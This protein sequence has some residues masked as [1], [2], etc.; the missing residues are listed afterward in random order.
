MKKSLAV[1]AR[2]TALTAVAVAAG[3]GE[4][5]RAPTSDPI[6]GVLQALVDEPNPPAIDVFE[7][8][9]C[10]VP[11]GVTDPLYADDAERVSLTA[12]G[13]IT[14]VAS[15]VADYFTTVSHGAYTPRFRAGGTV[16]IDRDDTS[17]TCIERAL[18][19]SSDEA[20]AVLVVATAQHVADQP[21]GRATPGDRTDAPAGL[22]GRMVYVGANDF[23]R[24]ALQPI[25]L[26][27]L[28]HE[29]GHSLGLAHSGDAV[30][31][32]GNR[33]VGPYDLMADPAS[34]RLVHPARRDGPDL[35]LAGRIALGWVPL[36]DVEVF[37]VD[38]LAGEGQAVS[39]SPSTGTTGTR[40]AIVVVDEHRMLTIEL[41]APTG[42]DDHLPG[43]GV[44]V[45]LIDD[46]PEQCGAPDRC[47]GVD[48][49]QQV[50]AAS[51]GSTLATGDAEFAAAGVAVRVTQGH[52]IGLASTDA[53][54]TH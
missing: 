20:D 22:T 38:D 49:V 23:H 29:I 24:D 28:E 4:P 34:P 43:A 41:L 5:D 45:H 16:H 9:V 30:G 39:L 18:D 32:T 35:L 19:A 2:V 36:G 53:D 6:D 15:G 42:F 46:R 44:V 1:V 31:A 7:V 26:D 40:G 54:A 12:E 47:T 27:L 37:G 8:W 21:G 52:L 33:G 13:V 48:R 51:D 11:T 10:D 14:T 3:C 17:E 25:A 50:V